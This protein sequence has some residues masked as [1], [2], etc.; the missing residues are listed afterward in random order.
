LKVPR[1]LRGD[2][3]LGWELFAPMLVFE[4]EK[5]FDF[6]QAALRGGAEFEGTV[7]TLVRCRTL[8]S[9]GRQIWMDLSDIGSK[10]GPKEAEIAVP[11]RKRGG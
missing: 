1:E 6:V 3:W 11:C 4:R 7:S 2:P 10:A 5:F 8:L 9:H